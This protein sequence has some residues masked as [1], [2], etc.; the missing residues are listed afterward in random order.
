MAT[1]EASGSSKSKIKH[2]GTVRSEKINKKGQQMIDQYVLATNDDG[3]LA[4]R[5]V[6]ATESSS[7]T[8]TTSVITATDDGK[9]AV[10]VVGGSGGG[11]SDPHNLG[12]YATQAALEEAHPTAEAGDWAIVG[13]TDTVWIW[14]TDTSAWVDSDQKGQVTSVNNQTGAVTIGANDVLPSQTG[15]S[16][17]VL[18]TDGFV[19]GWVK[20]EIVQRSTMPVA[21]QDEEGN[22]YQFV[23]ATDAN[24]TNG[25]FYECVSDGGN[26]ATYSWSQVN[27]QPSVDPL[28]SQTGNNGKYLTTNGSA[29]SWAT[30]SALQNTA[31]SS[32]SLTILGNA[33]TVGQ[34]NLN[35][36]QS[37]TVEGPRS[38]AIGVSARSWYPD[39][40]ALG[41]AAKADKEKA[42]AIGSGANVSV[43]GAGTYG[44]AIG[45]GATVTA[46]GAIQIGGNGR[47]NSESGTLCIGSGNN[48]YKLLDSN[49]TIPADRLPNAINK[50]S[51]MPTAAST[52]LGWIVQYTGTTNATYTHGYIYECVSDGGNPATYSW[53]A[54][55]VQ[56]GGGSSLPSQTGNSGKFLTT[57]GTDASWATISALQNVATGTDSIS[58][59]GPAATANYAI[60]MGLYSGAKQVGC[61][62]IGIAAN[63]GGTTSSD[64][65]ASAYGMYS[66][67]TKSASI[68]VGYQASA[69]AAGAAQIGTGTN[70]TANTLQFKDYPL[71]NS[72]GTIPTDRFTTTPS[73]DG[74]YVPTLTISSGVATRSWAA[75]S[76][77]GATAT[78][79]TL[80]TANWSSN[81]QTVS[82]T[83][84]TASN[85]VYVMA[86][87]ASAAEYAAAGVQCTAQASGTLTF[88][89]TTTPSSALTV[90]IAIF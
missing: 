83:G 13:A 84:V 66:S 67:A 23:G 90:N 34:D 76:G 46:G 43:N 79:A 37:S 22:I 9:L 31:T 55:S 33:A 88:T 25:Y 48:N 7:V 51:T 36:G 80:A 70:S 8:D 89:C 63:A 58:I 57:N 50:Y 75:P 65:N 17:R 29:A 24:Y 12:Y 73:A 15:Y 77:G 68:A 78:T 82:V 1:G 39:A 21:S 71:V 49:G 35:I 18:G 44:V 62:A 32:N 86:A 69:T 45:Y 64:V 11:G 41:C 5:T 81:S 27:V 26:P 74:T 85:V 19:A 61:T 38:T 10:R 56:A 6:S 20:P 3:D 47:T 4:I 16:G 42:I 72:D 53:S 28:P 52:N 60:N 40:T 59:L 54:V 2:I 87:P 14:D 30:I